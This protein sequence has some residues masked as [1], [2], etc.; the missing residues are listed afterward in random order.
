M[1]RLLILAG[2]ITGFILA[3]L[4]FMVVPNWIESTSVTAQEDPAPER[5]IIIAVED[6][7]VID[8]VETVLSGEVIVKLE[9]PSELPDGPAAADGIFKGQEGDTILVGNWQYRYF[10]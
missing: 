9:N 6:V 4:A 3:A 1:K 5:E 2:L 8:G 7:E 10:N